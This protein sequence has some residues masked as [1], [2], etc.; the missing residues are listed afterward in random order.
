MEK[1]IEIEYKHLLSANEYE[2]IKEFLIKDINHKIIKQENYYFET[3]DFKLKELGYALRIRII[4]G[5]EYELCLKQK[6]EKDILEHNYMISVEQFMAICKQPNLMREYV[7]E[8]LDFIALGVLNN[9]RIELEIENG[10]ICLD[11]SNYFNQDDYE[12][13]FEAN[14]YESE[15]YFVMFLENFGIKYQSNDKSKIQRFITAYRNN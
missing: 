4:N 1:N 11:K 15:E 3:S 14:D 5:N 7:N 6:R 13:E 12:I 2:L 10:L 9:T 8:E